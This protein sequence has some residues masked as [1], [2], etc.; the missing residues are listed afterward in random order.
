VEI[1]LR[2]FRLPSDP[3]QFEQRLKPAVARLI[4][5]GRPTPAGLLLAALGLSSIAV[6][7]TLGVKGGDLGYELLQRYHLD[8]IG[9]AYGRPLLAS[10]VFVLACSLAVA[11]SVPGGSLL[12]VLGG[13]LFGWVEATL[14]VQLASLA[15]ATAVFLLA[16]S[17]LAGR[18]RARAGPRLERLTD[19]FNRHAF[20]YVFVMHLFPLLPFGM[21]IALPAACGV[22]L[23]T[24]LTAAFLGLL[25]STL[26]LAHL[27]EGLGFAFFREGGVTLTSLL[28]PQI[29]LAAGGLAGL[30]LLPVVYRRLTRRELA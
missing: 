25:P 10:L 14:Y 3:R 6:V 21:I 16:R 8:L 24:Y 9:F 2:G 27:G 12:A 17:M 19:G 5:I 23:R 28:S 15:G 11:A 29:L 13:L 18:I 30:A 1:A 26:L 20:R 7:L 22:S 4:A